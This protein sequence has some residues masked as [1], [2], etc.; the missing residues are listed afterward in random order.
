M[1][2]SDLAGLRVLVTRPLPQA[3]TLAQS[4]RERGGISKIV[5]CLEIVALSTNQLVQRALQHCANADI[6][7]FISPNA[8]SAANAVMPL[9]TLAMRC[10]LA[11]GSGTAAA[12]NENGVDSVVTP[13]RRH[14]SESILDLPVMQDVC[15]KQICIVRGV[16][17]RETLRDKLIDRGADIQYVEVYR[18]TMPANAQTDVLDALKEGV[19][20]VL[21]NSGQTLDNLVRCFSQSNGELNWRSLPLFVPSTRVAELALSIGFEHVHKTVSP[22]DT[23]IVDSLLEWARTRNATESHER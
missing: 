18:R 23:G 5:P 13:C 16:G 2:S 21:V 19:D 3:A 12:L 1:T 14:D 6:V 20:I 4:I 8:V 7:I 15:G 10:V 22:N 17:G 11:P 9:A